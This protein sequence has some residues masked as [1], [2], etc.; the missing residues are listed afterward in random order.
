[1]FISEWNGTEDE[2]AIKYY[3]LTSIKKTTKKN[4]NDWKN[5]KDLGYAKLKICISV[6]FRYQK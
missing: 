6:Y 3:C 5:D 2:L 4:I 1:M